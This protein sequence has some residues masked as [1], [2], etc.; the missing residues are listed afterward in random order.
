VCPAGVQPVS[1][2]ALPYLGKESTRSLL[3]RQGDCHPGD[4]VLGGFSRFAVRV[5]RSFMSIVDK[6]PM[7]SP[8]LNGYRDIDWSLST[9]QGLPADSYS[10]NSTSRW[11]SRRSPSACVPV[12][13]EPAIFAS[14]REGWN[15]DRVSN[16]PC[17]PSRGRTGSELFAGIASATQWPS[18]HRH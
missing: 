7:H 9:A 2:K 4:C 13:D 8:K 1:S 18:A 14:S 11:R 10:F 6:S 15:Q 17:D 12:K 3:S 16:L 5:S